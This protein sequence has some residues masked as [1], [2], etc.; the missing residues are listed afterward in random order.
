MAAELVDAEDH[1][2][3]WEHDVCDTAH[4]QL[5]CPGAPRLHLARPCP[6]TDPVPALADCRDTSA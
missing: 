1:R 2:K 3:Q 6:L 4:A 5:P